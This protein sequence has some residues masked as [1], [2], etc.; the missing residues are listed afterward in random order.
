MAGKKKRRAPPKR[1]KAPAE[2]VEAELVDKARG[3]AVELWRRERVPARAI[4]EGVRLLELFLRGRSAKTLENYRIDLEDFAGFLQKNDIESA[5]GFLCSLDGP[6]AHALI[7]SYKAHLREKPVFRTGQKKPFRIGY[8]PSTINLRLAAIRS[9]IKIAKTI[10]IVTWTVEVPNEKIRS[11]RDTSGCGSE[12]YARLVS[13]L[14]DAI[15]G[16]EEQGKPGRV[17][18]K[19]RDLALVR[20]M[21]DAALRRKEPLTIDYPDDVD[22]DRTVRGKNRPRI[23]MLGKTR[24][25]KEWMTISLKA[26]AAI[27][28]WIESRG[29]HEGPLFV[30]FHPSYK[31]Q[32]LGN[33]AVNGMLGRL[34]KRTGVDHVT[35][36]QLRHSSITQALEKTGGDVRKVQR[37]SR[38]RQVQTVLLYDDNREDLAGDIA[39]LVSEDG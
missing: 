35:P 8:S 18:V 19:R 1:A 12:V 22:L 33:Q 11:Y 27:S 23:R 14:E 25:D 28:Q 16:F 24:D 20:L 17:A 3:A 38:H 10:G 37:F 34:A 30:S 13:T 29:D 2:V 5:V 7:L 36:H 39:E 21:Y 32:R 9:V 15:A 26:S 31:D 6:T 4:E